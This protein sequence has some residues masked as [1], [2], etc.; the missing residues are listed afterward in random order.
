MLFVPYQC[1]DMITSLKIVNIVEIMTIDFVKLRLVSLWLRLNRY[2]ASWQTHLLY[3]FGECH[4]KEQVN[5]LDAID[6]LAS[7]YQYWVWPCFSWCQYNAVNIPCIINLQAMWASCDLVW[8]RRTTVTPHCMEL[9]VRQMLGRCKRIT[10]PIPLSYMVSIP[11]HFS[12]YV[13]LKLLKSME[14]LPR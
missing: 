13:F 7:L 8:L 10:N 5:S 1:M 12:V 6:H 11:S 14:N 9:V 2:R 4:I 3:S